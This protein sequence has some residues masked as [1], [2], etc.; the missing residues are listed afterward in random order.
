MRSFSVARQRTHE[1]CHYAR[2]LHYKDA[3]GRD[4]SVKLCMLK[5]ND[6]D[7]CTNPADCNAFARRWSDEQVA[8]MFSKVMSDP[9]AKKRLYPELWAYEWVLDK[10]LTEAMKS[11]PFIA[12]PVVW[13]ISVL[14]SLLKF[15]SGN[16]NLMTHGTRDA[17]A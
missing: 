2:T 12:R 4:A 14:E 7:I 13:M 11:P 3:D 5:P 6:P 16:K 9:S 15:L 10:S 8:D 17:K 1:N